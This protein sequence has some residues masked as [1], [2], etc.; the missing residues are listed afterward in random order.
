MGW[1]QVAG[2]R[3]D[4]PKGELGPGLMVQL[5]VVGQIQPG[6]VQDQGG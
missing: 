5:L 4:G 3:G 1:G 2:K 6:R